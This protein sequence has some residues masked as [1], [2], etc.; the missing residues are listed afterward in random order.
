MEIGRVERDTQNISGWGGDIVRD[1]CRCDLD[2]GKTY[3]LR[4]FARDEHFEVFLDDRWIF[5]AVLKE[6]AMSG[7]VELLVERGQ[8]TFSDL[9]LATIEPLS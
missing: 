9:R 8:A 5:T 6:A 7:D 3:H 2:A 4:C 1:M